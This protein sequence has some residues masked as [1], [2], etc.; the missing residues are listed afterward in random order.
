MDK[1]GG[2]SSKHSSSTTPDV[3]QVSL[4]SV[5]DMQ[6]FKFTKVA[7]E[8]NLNVILLRGEGIRSRE[9]YFSLSHCSIF[10]AYN[11]AE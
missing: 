3:N 7:Q 10:F 2:E 1:A 11:R 9:P 8:E 6:S 4:Y 5:D